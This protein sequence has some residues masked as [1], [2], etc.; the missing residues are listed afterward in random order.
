MT[1]DDQIV[2][3]LHARRQKMASVHAHMR[4]LERVVTGKDPVTTPGENRSGKPAV[5][6]LPAQ[7]LEQ[8]AMRVASTEP[9]PVFKPLR[10]GLQSS[11]RRSA[12]RTEVTKT[13]WKANKLTLQ[14]HDRARH[15]IGYGMSPVIITW[16]KKL[17]IPKWETRSPVTCFPGPCHDLNR[18]TP[19]NV[20][21]EHRYT[22]DYLLRTW[23]DKIGML[24]VPQGASR[25]LMID[26]VEWHD[27]HCRKLIAVAPPRYDGEGFSPDVYGR[28]K[29][30]E[31]EMSEH[32]LGVCP[33][34]I[35]SRF[36]LTDD[37]PGAYDGVLDMHRHMQTLMALEV[38]AIEKGIWPD[39]WLEPLSDNVTPAVIQAPDGR[40]GVVG[41]ARGGRVKYE[42]MNPSF[43]ALQA[44][45]RFERAIRVQAGIPADWGGESA[46]NIRTGARGGQIQS[47]TVDFH[48]QEHQLLLSES[49]MEEDR[50][51]ILWDRKMGGGRRKYVQVYADG[52]PPP[53]ARTYEADKLWET[54]DHDVRYAVAGADAAQLNIMVAQK[55]GTGILSADTARE[56]DPLVD[57]PEFEKRRVIAGRLEEATLGGLEQ[58][59][60]AGE[61]P[62]VDAARII[63]VYL[64]GVP[65]HE[66]VTR[67]QREAQER[68]AAEVPPSAPEAQPGLAMPGMGAEA[69]G[70]VIPEVP[71]DV[72]RLASVF[73][74]ARRPNMMLP[75]EQ[76]AA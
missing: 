46:T 52:S 15:L 62:M 31:L 36:A 32:D 29:T 69:G 25:D 50:R 47:A 61:V 70:G 7:A 59:I 64:G 66:A 26:V 23:P 9:M 65:L 35:P 24:Y 30:V 44:T 1:P 22:L 57:D 71:P 41:I 48:I 58:Q 68:Q 20:I 72:D 54:T 28:A 5:P 42:Q 11:E 16:D 14:R 56:L 12:R 3:L 4:E 34:V 17:D 73:T 75:V 74:S 13:W 38:E 2:S 39:P 55:M 60:A 67:V 21:F 40:E 19:P 51:A 45:D 63:E 27:D 37:S 43:A 6:N 53:G 49:Q 8:M 18:L 33:V 76:G 10:P